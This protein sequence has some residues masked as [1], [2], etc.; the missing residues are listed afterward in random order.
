MASYLMT[1]IFTLN[2]P[3]ILLSLK[4]NCASAYAMASYFRTVIFT[5]YDPKILLSLKENYA[6]EYICSIGLSWPSSNDT[7]E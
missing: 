2:D 6:L 5:A 7:T 1:V 4:E 3:K